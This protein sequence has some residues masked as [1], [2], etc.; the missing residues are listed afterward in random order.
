MEAVGIWN[1]ELSSL[2][3]LSGVKPLI[4]HESLRGGA[5]TDWSDSLFDIDVVLLKGTC[6]SGGGACYLR[7]RIVKPPRKQFTYCRTK[8]AA[9]CRA[10]A[11]KSAAHSSIVWKSD[12]PVSMPTLLHE[13][14]HVLGLTDYE[15]CEDLRRGP[16]KTTGL[17]Q[18]GDVEPLDDHFSLMRNNLSADCRHRGAITGRDLRDLYESYRVEPITGVRLDGNASLGSANSLT[19]TLFWGTDGAAEAAHNASHIAVLRRS[20]GSSVW[21]F[22]ITP[23]K[24]RETGG[25]VRESITVTDK[26]GAAV[27]YKI[28]GLTRGDIRL[29]GS[30]DI[31][32]QF[33]VQGEKAGTTV[34]GKFAEG[35]PTMVVGVASYTETGSKRIEVDGPAV[36]SAS[37][38]PRYCYVNRSLAVEIT[39]TGGAQSAS[40]S[41]KGPSGGFVSGS[42]VSCG[43][44]AGERQVT[45]KSEWGTGAS[46][47]TWTL[48]LP[49]KVNPSPQR[50]R[51]LAATIQP[52]GGGTRTTITSCATGETVSIQVSPAALLDDLDVW[53]NDKK[54]DSNPLSFTCPAAMSSTDEVSV[55]ALRGDGGRAGE[56]D[57]GILSPLTARL[58]QRAPHCRAGQET[59]ARLIIQGG[60]PGY[61]YADK[62]GNPVQRTPGAQGHAYTY[63]YLPDDWIAAALQRTLLAGGRT[64]TRPRDNEQTSAP[65]GI[66]LPTSGPQQLSESR[67]CFLG[68]GTLARQRKRDDVDAEMAEPAPEGCGPLPGRCRNCGGGWRIR[69]SRGGL[70]RRFRGGDRVA[71]DARVEGRATDLRDTEAVAS[72]TCVFLPG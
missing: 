70:G 53:V 13:L 43:S 11:Y 38:S 22:A 16:D 40:K 12:N 54:L 67:L 71:T 56:M 39:P 25:K 37:L 50:V 24:V 17:D 23:P 6:P 57:L 61:R 66:P 21:T 42:S 9:D 45:V 7:D 55:F 34:T 5:P 68:R 19:F 46:T 59:V 51:S 36:L 62:A 64:P 4:A 18:P 65:L 26:L 69:W 14:G 49:V 15:S 20:R 52:T 3:V 47:V 44:A 8:A 72:W 58:V 30:F 10:P 2:T 48:T 27:A 32:R 63:D 1:A 29:Q 60:R 28:V 31:S 33:T 35:D 41:V